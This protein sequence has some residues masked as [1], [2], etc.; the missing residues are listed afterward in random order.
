MIL[1]VTVNPCID[2]TLSLERYRPGEKNHVERV[3]AI[4]GGKGVNVARMAHNLG[5]EVMALCLLGGTSGIEITK[6]L[7][8]DGIPYH[9]VLVRERSR[10]ITTIRETLG[11]RHTV[12]FEPG[13]V[14]TDEERMHLLTA[15]ERFLPTAGLVVLGGP[16]PNS[17]YD[18]IYREMIDRARAQ[19]K[20]V[21]LDSHGTG[22]REGIDALPFLV[23]PN[24]EE[25][26]GN[27]RGASRKRRGRSAVGR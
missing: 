16:V 12:F 24:Q 27:N 8:R 10:E 20:K 5:A 4:A 11:E 3:E 25:A 6:L 23:K 9:G 21:I 7:A 14:L 2:K 22:L 19:G 15:Y 17:T 13:P 1:T 18:G 26:A